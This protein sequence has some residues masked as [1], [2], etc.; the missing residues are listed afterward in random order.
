MEIGW[1]RGEGKIKENN[2]KCAKMKIY[3]ERGKG[4]EK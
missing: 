1:E 3:R 2:L 4:K